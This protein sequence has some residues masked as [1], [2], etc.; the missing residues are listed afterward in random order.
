VKD[1]TCSDDVCITCADQLLEVV[2]VAVSADGSTATVTCEGTEAE[3]SIDLVDGV[4]AGDHLLSHGGVALQRGTL[5]T[6]R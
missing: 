3:V 4:G 6:S 1:V 5:G 2:V